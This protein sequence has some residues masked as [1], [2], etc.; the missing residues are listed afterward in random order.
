METPRW[1]ECYPSDHQPALEEVSAWIAAPLFDEILGWGTENGLTASLEYS[2]CGMDPGWNVKLKKKSKAVCALYPRRG[3]FA[4][5]VVLG[6]K[7]VPLAEGLMEQCSPE[8]RDRFAQAGGINGSRWLVLDVRS[9]PVLE[10]VERLSEL[11]M[12][13]K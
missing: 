12:L 1:H 9:R 8:T 11:K 6:P 7:L 10:D 13:A 3:F 2:R 4:A 5:M